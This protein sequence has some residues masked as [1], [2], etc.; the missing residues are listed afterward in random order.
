MTCDPG[1]AS[2]RMT[3]V[4]ATS[5]VHCIERALARIEVLHVREERIQHKGIFLFVLSPLREVVVRLHRVAYRS[6]LCE[7]KH[8]DTTL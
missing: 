4:Y 1:C 6:T 5:L 2:V 7:S 3:M 8:D